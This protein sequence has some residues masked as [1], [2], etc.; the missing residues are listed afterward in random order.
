[1]SNPSDLVEALATYAATTRD[2]GGESSRIASQCSDRSAF[3]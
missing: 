2:D 1:M 3:E